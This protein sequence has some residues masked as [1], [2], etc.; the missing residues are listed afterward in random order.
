[1]FELEEKCRDWLVYLMHTMPFWSRRIGDVLYIDQSTDKI[2]EMN[3]IREV[4]Q[5]VETENSQ[6][7]IYFAI[8]TDNAR[9]L[10]SLYY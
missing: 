3:L 10:F 7:R 9:P 1:M 6:P 4:I 2:K 8:L 5:R